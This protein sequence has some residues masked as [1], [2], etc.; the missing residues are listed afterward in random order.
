MHSRPKLCDTPT[1]LTQ[2]SPPSPS[3]ALETTLQTYAQQIPYSANLGV[4]EA[5]LAPLMTQNILSWPSM[6]ALQKKGR[7]LPGTG[8]PVEIIKKS[9]LLQDPD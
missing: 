7:S 1:S 6:A 5:T 9:Q 2:S 3:P 8:S 4:F